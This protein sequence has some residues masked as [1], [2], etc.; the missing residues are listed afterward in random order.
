MKNKKGFTLVELLAVIVILALIMG[1]AVVSIGGVLK[2]SRESTFKETALS[3]IN[4]V[5][6]QL[7]VANQLK[8]GTY[9]FT[10]KL[11]DNDNELPFGGMINYGEVGTSNAIK[12]TNGVIGSLSGISALSSCNASQTSFVLIEND[13]E[14]YK[15]SICLTPKDP[16]STSTKK[17]IKATELQLYGND[18]VVF[19]TISSSSSS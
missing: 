12:G 7:T 17:Y 16:T 6:M 5:K 8:A 15:F 19:D 4:G 1:I 11:L 10:N 14:K 3:I 13:Q 18:T 2:S 9:V